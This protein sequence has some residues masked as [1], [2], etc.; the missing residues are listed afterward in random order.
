MNQ[1]LSFIRNFRPIKGSDGVIRNLVDDDLS[2]VSTNNGVYIL[3][4]PR[5][6]FVYP[7]GSSNQFSHDLLLFGVCAAEN[8]DT[9]CGSAQ[10]GTGIDGGH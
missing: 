7:K 8:T 10:I 3:V 2:E 5:T 4:S 6:R 1:C 9:D